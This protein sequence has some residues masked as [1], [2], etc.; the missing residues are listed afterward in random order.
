MKRKGAL[1]M[2]GLLGT[3]GPGVNATVAGMMDPKARCHLTE[4]PLEWA[5]L[6]ALLGGEM[7]PS[8]FRFSTPSP[9][10]VQLPSQILS[11]QNA[12]LRE[13]LK[14]KPRAPFRRRCF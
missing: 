11:A 12:T 3:G 6:L 4:S 13:V 8:R 14:E 2:L 10:C 9:G 5:A 1:I 7:G